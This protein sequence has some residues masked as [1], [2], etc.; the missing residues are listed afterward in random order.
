MAADNRYI[1]VM[2]EMGTP[3]MAY[4]T[5]NTYVFGGYVVAE[6][7][8]DQAVGAWRQIKQELCGDADAELK[9][10]HFF[11]DEDDPHI[12]TPLRDK[13]AKV[14]R[15]QAVR[16]LDGLFGQASIRPAMLIVEKDRA[17]ETLIA[18]SRKGKDKID[19]DLIWLVPAAQF[20]LFLHV[21]RARGRLWCDSLG[22]EKQEQRRQAAWSEQLRMVRD[23]EVPDTASANLQKLLLIDD[24]VK[25]FDSRNNE[26]VQ[27]ADFVCGV[28]WAA[29]EGDESYLRRFIHKYG[30]SAGRQ[31]LGI[32]H[33][34]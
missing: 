26:A 15:R 19:D 27:I 31:G 21:H 13:E 7:E 17:T 20:S 11:V 6:D 34:A 18:Q 14:R 30:Q 5:S 12:R 23:G 9:W 8:L 16:A 10:K 24:H 25:F 32:V 4:G 28:I 29:G 33:I 22:S 1:L 2:D 3:G